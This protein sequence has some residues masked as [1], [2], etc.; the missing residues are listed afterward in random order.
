MKCSWHLCNKELLGRQTKYCSLVCKNKTSVTKSRKSTKK[1]LVELFGGKCE[2]CGWNENQ[3]ALDFHHRNPKEKEFGLGASGMTFAFSK[4][5]EEAN[6]C[7][8]LCSNCHR[9]IHATKDREW[10]DY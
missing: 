6:K 5:N 10:L 7:H 3:A 4:L 9:V 1:K 8:L 2:R